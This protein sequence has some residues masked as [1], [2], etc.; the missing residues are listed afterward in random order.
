MD[1][2]YWYIGFAAIALI[3]LAFSVFLA[4]RDD[5][6]VFQKVAQI[7]LVWCVPFFAALGLWLFY[8]T[9]DKPIGAPSKFGGG[10][11]DISRGADTLP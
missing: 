1:L 7:I 9:Q 10:G 4:K 8:R 6:D 11:S 5:L 3:N 2:N